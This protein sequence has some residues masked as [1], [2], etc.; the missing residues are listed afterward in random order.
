MKLKVKQLSVLIICV[1]AVFTATSQ[2][3]SLRS[4][5]NREAA[6]YDAL[7]V[8]DSFIYCTGIVA[9]TAPPYLAKNVFSKYTISGNLVYYKIFRGDSSEKEIG[10]FDNALISTLDGGFAL[11]GYVRTSS[12]AIKGLLIKYDST[13]NVEFYKTYTHPTSQTFFGYRIIEDNTGFY[14]QGTLAYASLDIGL[15][16]I[17]TDSLGNEQWR[18]YYGTNT[19]DELAAAFIRT[20]SNRLLIAA[21][22][23]NRK[24]MDDPAFV[25]YSYLL[26]LDTVGNIIRDSIGTDPNIGIPQSLIETQDENFVYCT[27]Y[28][29]SKT[30]AYGMQVKEYMAK[31][32]TN[33][34]LLWEGVY[35]DTCSVNSFAGLYNVVEL[36]DSSLIAV[37]A[38]YNPALHPYHQDGI[39]IK[40]DANGSQIWSRE[41]RGVT[42]IGQ[43]LEINILYDCGVLNDGSIVACGIAQ[44]DNDT[45]PQRAWLLRIDANGCMDNN[46]CG[47][48]GI[49]EVKNENQGQEMVKIY[50]N[51]FTTNLNIL[52]QQEDLHQATFT[53]I[54]SV[55][56]TIYH[57][58]ETNLVTNYTKVL[59]LSYLPNG[60]HLL[61]V[62]I[63]G[64]RTIKQIIKQ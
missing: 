16:L 34:N 11:T 13:G 5:L 27:N 36:N 51:P 48:T 28:A 30:Q 20:S 38:N 9:D 58:E 41:Y 23:N 18:R 42:R 4:R 52:L 15:F 43:Q 2:T 21:Q 62:T 12:Y 7:I 56:Q 63:D 61:E 55:G 35:G 6:Q 24:S 14:I 22:K 39:V 26:L 44:D 37:G 17:K 60:V 54:N 45:F 53:I 47:Y 40:T 57:R 25:S 49:N 19:T 10:T 31:I 46:W 1:L 59:D 33:L 8:K 64:Q 29:V 32:D 3:Y 50:P